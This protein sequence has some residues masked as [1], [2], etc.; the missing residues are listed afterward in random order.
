MGGTT[1]NLESFI[2]SL[3][4]KAED[5]GAAQAMAIPAT[6]I[7]VDERTLLKC[8]VPLCS[9]YGVELMCP[10]NVLPMSKFKEILKC[11]HRAIL[12]KVDIPL[13][14]LPG[15]SGKGEGQPGASVAE[16]YMNA[17]RDIQKRLHEIVS[18]V[19]SLCLE[20]GYHFAT[21][22]VGGSCPLC[23][24]CVGTK[25]GLPCRHPYRARPAMEAMGI[26]VMATAE[27]AGLHLNFAQSGSWSWVGVVLV[28]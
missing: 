5:L 3:C 19:E 28:A 26:D 23:E 20:E 9:H 6:D 18:R 4:Q 16:D 17:A 12:I 2:A 1:K 22:L 7:V 27:K 10:P 13:S 24:E 11:Y 25:Y 8:M 14:D 21:G 15:S